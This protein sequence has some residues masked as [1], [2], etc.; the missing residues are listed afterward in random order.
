MALGA[1][2]NVQ[3]Q[4]IKA[5]H[6]D[7]YIECVPGRMCANCQTARNASYNPSSCFSFLV[8]LQHRFRRV[9][10]VR[11]HADFGHHVRTLEFLR[12]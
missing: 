4:K 1:G 7:A 5:F 12:Y 3:N 2:A 6:F 8:G 9:G 10:P 11:A